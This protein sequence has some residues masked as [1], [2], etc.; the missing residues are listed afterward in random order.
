MRLVLTE[1]KHRG[2]LFLDS[3]T[4]G[5]SVGDKVAA[6]VGVPFAQRDVFLD[7]VQS[8]Q[9]VEARLAEAFGSKWRV[10]AGPTREGG[11]LTTM[12]IPA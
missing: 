1:L 2:L 8:A 6:Q 3:R 5:N 9:E 11:W 4:I 7:N 10:V 12:E